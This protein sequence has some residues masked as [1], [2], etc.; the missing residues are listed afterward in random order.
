MFKSCVI[1]FKIIHGQAP[2][3]LENIINFRTVHRLRSD[4]NNT[5]FLE[6]PEHRKCLEFGMVLNWNNL[7]VHIRAWAL[8]TAD[9]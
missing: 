7:P 4:A 3:Y 8:G 1:V 5:N 2:Q 6:Y 9:S